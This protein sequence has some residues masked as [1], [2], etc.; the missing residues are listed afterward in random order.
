MVSGLTTQEISSQRSGSAWQLFLAV[1]DQGSGET[2]GLWTDSFLQDTRVF[3][4]TV[5]ELQVEFLASW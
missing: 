4:E 3:I 2:A 5:L 1:K